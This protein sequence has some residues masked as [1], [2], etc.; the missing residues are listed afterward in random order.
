MLDTYLL[1]SLDTFDYNALQGAKRLVVIP[2]QGKRFCIWMRELHDCADQSCKKAFR[3]G[4][5]DLNY[6]LDVGRFVANSTSVQQV[7]EALS[8]FAPEG[9]KWRFETR[10]WTKRDEEFME[11]V[12]EEGTVEEIKA[13]RKNKGIDE[14]V[15]QNNYEELMIQ[16]SFMRKHP[17]VAD[18]AATIR[19]RYSMDNIRFPM[20]A[21]I[22]CF[23][24][25]MDVSILDESVPVNTSHSGKY[26]MITP[27]FQL[28]DVPGVYVAG[29]LSHSLDFR[30]SAGGFIHGFR[31]TARALF[32]LLEEKNEG[33]EWPH[34]LIPLRPPSAES[35]GPCKGLD[36][37]VEKL[38]MR[39]N[40]ASGPYQMFQAL[41]DMV[42]FEADAE[43]GV[44]SARYME[45]VPLELFNKRYHNASRLT[46]VF[47]YGEGFHGKKVLSPERV[48]A[49]SAENA[50]MS[51]FLHPCLTFVP[52][53]AENSTRSHWLTE[54]IFTF[55]SSEEL[56]VSLAKF[57]A[58]VVADATGSKAFV[59][60]GAFST[61]RPEPLFEDGVI[62]G[63]RPHS[64]EPLTTTAT[65]QE[66][67]TETNDSAM[68]GAGSMQPSEASDIE[69]E[70]AMLQ[71]RQQMLERRLNAIRSRTSEL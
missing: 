4:G 51:N 42:V 6:K 7:R 15:F 22:R 45:E 68:P 29:T 37:L 39:I 55:W 17:E 36:T 19:G 5:Q 23:G 34:D 61:F 48:G 21:V 71:E 35:P 31:Y 53:G 10:T 9:N 14:A 54:D 27:G 12:P 63:S 59:K 46:W 65:P 25:A 66:K 58:R 40:S 64:E 1:K 11:A 50:D 69:K 47:R 60:D 44:W 2:C 3:N 16:S 13:R 8:R 30:R 52:G 56:F 38:R 24:W 62:A 70:M 43:S 41:G 32:R 49:T 20:D 67:S 18:L 26:P 28:Q 33:L 57:V